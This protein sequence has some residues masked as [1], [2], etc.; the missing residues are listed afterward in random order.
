MARSVATAPARQVHLVRILVRL[1]TVPLQTD[2]VSSSNAGMEG[3]QVRTVTVG[4]AGQN[5]LIKLALWPR[6]A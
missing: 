4:G 1:R 3:S 5:T 6:R 2:P